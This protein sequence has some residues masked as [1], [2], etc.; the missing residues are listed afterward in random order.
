MVTES[1]HKSEQYFVKWIQKTQVTRVT[2]F[3]FVAKTKNIE[4]YNE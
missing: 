1:V 3:V 2:F 4:F